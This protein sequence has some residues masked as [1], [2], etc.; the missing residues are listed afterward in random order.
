MQN[1]R[2]WSAAAR[3][4][5]DGVEDAPWTVVLAHGAGQPM[6][7]PFMSAFAQG[8]AARP[9]MPL[10]VVRFEFPYMAAARGGRRRPPDRT[11]VLADTWRGIIGTLAAAGTP[12]KRLVVGGKSLGGRIA[13][14]MADA[15]AVAGVLCLGYP[16]HPPGKP[17]RLRT[18]HLRDLRTPALICQGT[19]DP[20]GTREE[21]E[22]YTLSRRVRIHWLEDGDHSF[23]PRRRAAHTEA[24][25]LRSAL[26][27]V[28]TFIASL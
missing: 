16:F 18:A 1:A 24:D 23:K 10:R 13:S 9:G 6:D 27:A 5:I 17:E 14:Q 19:R 25:N 28:A 21:V 3:F 11:D 2:P 22:T 26:D 7:S 12:R 15:E 4:L 8:L 20:F